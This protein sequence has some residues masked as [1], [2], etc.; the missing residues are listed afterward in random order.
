MK[1]SLKW[2]SDHV[3]FGD[4]SIDE[5][6]DL[7]TFTG[8]EVE[9]IHSLP[10]NLIVA[11][12]LSSEKHPD[13]DK[14]S[15]CTVNDGS[16]APRQIVC[17]AKNY[18]VGDQVPLALPGCTLTSKDGKTFEIK[19]GKLRGVESHGMMCSAAELHLSE[20]SDGLMILPADLEPGTVLSDVYPAVFDLEIT[21][22]RPD[23]LSHLGVARELAAV[24]S[25]ELKT[26]PH[27]GGV[28]ETPKTAE[29]SEIVLS[30]ENCPYYTGRWIRGV[31]VGES[32]EWLKEKLNAIGLRPINNIVD[33][34]NFVLME[35]GQPL[36]AF[37][38]AKV[39]GAIQVRDAKEGEEF[40][41]LDG[42]TCALKSTDVVIA[43]DNGAIALG[44]VMGG[45]DSGVTEETTDILLE[46]AWFVPSAVRR[47]ARRLD[48]HSDSS[49]RFE[50]GVDPHQV[51]GASKLAEELI[52]QL[53]G[54][55]ADSDIVVA[56]K[57]P[58]SPMPVDLDT[59]NVRK[60]MGCDVGDEHITEILTALGLD[61]F[62]KDGTYAMWRIPT[63]R[64]DLTR[65][66]D[67]IEEVAR[68]YGLDNVP[69]SNFAPYTP[70]SKAD[71][72]YDFSRK[73]QIRLSGLGFYETR[74]LKLIGEAELADD[75]ATTHR[76]MSPIRLKNPL[77]DEQDYLRPGLVPGLLACAGRN[78]RFGN[79]DLRLFETGRVFT[80]TPKGDEIEHEHLA[81]LMTGGRASRSWHDGKPDPVDLFDLRGVI[82]SLCPGKDVK[83]K[84]IEDNRLLCA[85]SIEIGSGKKA[86][87][88][89]LAGFVPPG[90][91]REFDLEKPV[92]VAEFNMKKLAAAIT[93]D[94]KFAELPKFPGSSR[95][96]AM[97]VPADLANTE[98]EA[99]FENR[100]EP[101]LV[102]FE[103]F[104]VFQ[105]PSG[106]K[107]ASD[108][109]SLAYSL[110]YRSPDRTL[111]AAE[112]ET[113]HG[114]LLDSLKTELPVEFR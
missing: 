105:D 106:K 17:G 54:G 20:D 31:K 92:A 6:S 9:G 58:A 19:S 21:P 12:V 8:I 43:D 81:L 35:M 89:G 16:D 97:L 87:K 100:N 37:D 64:L 82:E 61:S 22:N 52:F 72:S 14:L 109:K 56:G 102:D 51:I 90:R 49:Y 83:F 77:N 39:K 65:E 33:I 79:A 15:V 59:D 71:Q 60:L 42:E 50:R 95:D 84:A 74:N 27:F 111:E 57:A 45:E 69:A 28:K 63:Y 75:C 10:A 5:L 32:P 53:A 99:F 98:V 40:L 80:A 103:L 91:A 36:H 46:S 113:A 86:A 13:A 55:K 88:L 85:A 107:L 34:T 94:V 30:S 44:G 47:T 7:L 41:A 112:V 67:L 3:D 101:L 38:L 23:C 1:V 11:E 96:I 66:V 78:V 104:D 2:L 4:L 110:L 76:G 114:K 108:K 25:R 24:G 68:V 48:L 73:I 29:D 70:A 93:G 62:G 26:Q 18:K